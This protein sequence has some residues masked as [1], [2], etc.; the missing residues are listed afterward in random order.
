MVR[1]CARCLESRH[2][3]ISQ[4]ANSGPIS[5]PYPTTSVRICIILNLMAIK[6]PFI[7]LSS[8][9]AGRGQLSHP[10]T[11]WLSALNVV[12]GN[13][14]ASFT[15]AVSGTCLRT[16]QP[17][18]ITPCGDLAPSVPARVLY[19]LCHSTLAHGKY[20]LGTELAVR[21][22]VYYQWSIGVSTT[23][24]ASSLQ[25]LFVPCISLEHK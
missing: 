21:F 2:L 11:I 13:E 25:A 3:S 20:A 18:S 9:T 1:S 17:P 12:V 5:W 15:I 7:Q 10:M 8:G 6:L 23:W 4:D 22:G 14:M 19:C 24:R 16:D